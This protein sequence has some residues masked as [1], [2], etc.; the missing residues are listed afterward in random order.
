MHC[1]V[2]SQSNFI[3]KYVNS[4]AIQCWHKLSYEWQPYLYLYMGGVESYATIG[5]PAVR[6]IVIVCPCRL[7]SIQMLSVS[8]GLLQKDV[9]MIMTVLWF[10]D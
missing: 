4:L 7:S 10:I 2:V 9:V 6:S 8:G 1:V 3:V 5:F